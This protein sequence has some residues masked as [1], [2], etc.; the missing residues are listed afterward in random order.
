MTDRD[1]TLQTAVDDAAAW[2]THHLAGRLLPGMDPGHIARTGIE[3]MYAEL[4]WRPWPRS[5]RIPE[6]GEGDPATARRG[7]DY[8][9]DLL[10]RRKT[11]PTEGDTD[12]A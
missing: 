10:A 5:D 11:E 9:R 8:A 4:G 1:P 7:A 2:W 6:P 12:G 3:H